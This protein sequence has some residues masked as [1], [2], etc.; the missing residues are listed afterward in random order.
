MSLDSAWLSAIRPYRSLPIRTWLTVKY[1]SAATATI[2]RIA[3]CRNQH[4]FCFVLQ[5]CN[6]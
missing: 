2:P 1:D 6:A 5:V 3:A 4:Q